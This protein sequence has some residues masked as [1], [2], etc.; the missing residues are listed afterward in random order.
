MEMVNWPARVY[1]RGGIQRM[2]KGQ[3]INLFGEVELLRA[4]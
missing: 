2:N 1:Y 3:F 4:A